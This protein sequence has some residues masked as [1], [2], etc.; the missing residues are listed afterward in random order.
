MSTMFTVHSVRGRSGQVRS[1]QVRSGQVRS[2]QVRS[3]QVR[4]GQVRSDQVKVDYLHPLFGRSYES[5]HIHHQNH[6]VFGFQ[7][8]IHTFLDGS[9]DPLV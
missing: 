5:A 4:S 3:G 7:I 1:G 6:L 2:G 9:H 8:H